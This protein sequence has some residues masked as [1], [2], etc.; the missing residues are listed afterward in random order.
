MKIIILCAGYGKRINLNKPK[1]LIKIKGET[2]LKNTIK[3]LK[4]NKIKNDQIHLALGYQYKKILKHT[5]NKYKFSLVK[6][7]KKTNMVYSL[8]NCVKKF[9][10]TDSMILYGDILYTNEIIKKIINSKK[11]LVTAVDRNWHKIWKLTNRIENDLE[12]LQIKKN[13]I[14]NI[15]YPTK[16][17]KNIDGRYIGATKFDKS[18]INFFIKFYKKK[19][20][21]D[22]K[23]YFNL[24]MTKL[25][26]CLIKNNFKLNY[27]YVNQK[28]FEFDNQDDVQT[29]K[30]ILSNDNK[31]FK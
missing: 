8:Y 6:N 17:I 19:L 11:K 28:W 1:C 18:L 22:P 23:K 30:K 14:I 2:L 20:I 12:T 5:N 3:L 16:N 24:D 9:E 27:V 26:M 25:L 15:G 31:K 10:V 7:F 21:Q 29:Y 13:Q 4:K